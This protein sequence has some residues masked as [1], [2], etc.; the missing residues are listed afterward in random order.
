MEVSIVFNDPCIECKCSNQVIVCKKAK[1]YF[2]RCKKEVKCKPGQR[3]S[4]RNSCPVCVDMNGYCRVQGQPFSVTN[5]DS[6]TINY[7]GVFNHILARDCK[8]KEFSIHLLK[9]FDPDLFRYNLSSSLTT[10][11]FNAIV[12][13][14][15]KVKVRLTR[16]NV[17]IG[18]QT[19]KLPY[20]RA[21]LT[22]V[23]HDTKI[24]L[25]ASNGEL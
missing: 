13:R 7:D 17:K 20:I 16:Y 6:K 2:E 23:R 11:S 12:V 14:L 4:I 25:R 24:A 8:A 22:I 18:R 1:C 9:R 10:S 3:I 15:K 21:G 19:V 5:F